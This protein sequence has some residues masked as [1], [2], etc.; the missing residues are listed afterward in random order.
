MNQNAISRNEFLKAMGIKGAALL[1]VYC[2]GQSLT[3]CSKNN[4][5]SPAPLSGTVTVDLT[6]PANAGLLKQGGYIVTNNVVVANTSRGYVA[7]TVVCSHE[8]QRK[9]QLRNDEF[10]CPEH[11]ARY[12]LTGKGLNS[13]GRNGLT[14]YTVTQAGNTLTIS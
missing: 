6:A 8:G 4:G 10:Y 12:D 14:V 2:A 7:V 9:V 13:E 3:A 5:V 1:A 11:G